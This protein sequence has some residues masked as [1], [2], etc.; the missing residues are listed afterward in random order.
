MQLQT[1]NDE[2]KWF[3]KELEK[4]KKQITPGQVGEA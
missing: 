2:I 1:K 4:Y 3:E